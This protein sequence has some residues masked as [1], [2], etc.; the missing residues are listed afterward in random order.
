MRKIIIAGWCL[1]SLAAARPGFGQDRPVH[2]LRLG[3]GAA[4]P[5]N[6][7]GWVTDRLQTGWLVSVG[8]DYFLHPNWALEVGGSFQRNQVDTEDSPLSDLTLFSDTWGLHAGG[9]ANW[10][11]RNDFHL[12]ADLGVGF[13][14]SLLYA[15]GHRE[16]SAIGW[17]LPLGV[18]AEFFLPRRLCLG[19]R[20]GYL[21]RFMSRGAS[22]DSLSVQVQIGTVWGR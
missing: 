17:G 2:L 14:Q 13:Y 20:L 8:Y 5:V 11:V 12:H 4:F 10:P 21:P 3:A 1:W 18:G 19:L 9:R 7:T 16:D 15:E 6:G 22:F